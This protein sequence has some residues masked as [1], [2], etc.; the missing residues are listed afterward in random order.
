MNLRQLLYLVS[1]IVMISIIASLSRLGLAE[2]ESITR[3]GNLSP[4]KY[5]KK[6]V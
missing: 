5:S 6:P 4:I 2:N 1:T 3:M